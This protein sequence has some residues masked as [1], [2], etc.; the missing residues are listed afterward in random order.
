MTHCRSLDEARQDERLDGAA[1]YR[2]AA[3]TVVDGPVDAPDDAGCDAVAGAE[4]LA[5]ES[6]LR[7]DVVV[8]LPVADRPASEVCVEDAGGPAG[9]GVAACVFG[10][11]ARAVAVLVLDSAV[12]GAPVELDVVVGPTFAPLVPVVDVTVTWSYPASGC[13]PPSTVSPPGRPPASA[14]P[15]TVS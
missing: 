7:V 2:A 8:G 9:V 5:V 6:E 12:V 13:R 15:L 3:A 11:R 1:P 10:V 4:L 14:V